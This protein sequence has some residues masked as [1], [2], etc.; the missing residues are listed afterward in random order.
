MKF[1]TL[2]LKAFEDLSARDKEDW[3]RKALLKDYRRFYANALV[4]YMECGGHNK[5]HYNEVAMSKWASK[6]IEFGGQV[7]PEA[8]ALRWGVFNG[9][10]SY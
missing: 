2:E 1:T 7:P 8:E 3:Q 4:T 6:I 9:D 5:A 10:G